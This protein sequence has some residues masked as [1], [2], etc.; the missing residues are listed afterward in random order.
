MAD[1]EIDDKLI[2]HYSNGL[3]R[4]IV[5]WIISKEKIHGYGIMKRLDEFF[6][7]RDIDFEIKNK[8]S[9]IYPILREME[10]NL[11]IVGEWDINEN[12][13]RVKYYSI[14]DNGLLI[15]DKLRCFIGLMSN[16]P[17][18]IDFY[19]DMGVEINEKCN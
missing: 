18:W 1:K 2:K 17:A 6:D 9:K 11:L 15:L 4:N 13:K 5:L 3:V 7:F 16:N 19:S 14:T 10:D 8:S 12:N